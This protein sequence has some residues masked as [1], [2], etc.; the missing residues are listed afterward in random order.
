M[1]AEHVLNLLLVAILAALAVLLLVG[2]FC[3]RAAPCVA[4]G[5]V[6][7]AGIEVV[8]LLLH[9]HRRFQPRVRLL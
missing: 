8:D 4:N 3:R 9:E 2:M 7:M 6:A 1:G 5:Q